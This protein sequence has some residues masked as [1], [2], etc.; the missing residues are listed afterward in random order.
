MSEKQRRFTSKSEAR[1]AYTARLAE[2]TGA[3]LQA[4]ATYLNSM[5]AAL[6]EHHEAADGTIQGVLL[7]HLPTESRIGL[8]GVTCPTCSDQ[9]HEDPEP[10]SWPC[11]T[12]VGLAAALKLPAVAELDA[13]RRPQFRDFWTDPYVTVT[14]AHLTQAQGVADPQA[15]YYAPSE[16]ATLTLAE[17][18]RVKSR[19]VT[20]SMQRIEALA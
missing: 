9:H 4:V 15:R 17:A 13:D 14:F 12:Y 20:T 7:L 11:D 6:G 3:H 2:F 5:H 19:L 16:Q 18:Q 10:E 1:A 8:N